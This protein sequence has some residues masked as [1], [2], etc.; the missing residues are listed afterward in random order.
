MNQMMASDNESINLGN[1]TICQLIFIRLKSS[2]KTA[3]NFHNY[4]K[5]GIFG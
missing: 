1:F 5:T 4:G 3:G 2:M